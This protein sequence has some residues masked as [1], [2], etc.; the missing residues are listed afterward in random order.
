[1]FLICI[2][3]HHCM[4][5]TFLLSIIIVGNITFVHL[6]LLIIF[7]VCSK[8]LFTFFYAYIYIECVIYHH[9]VTIKLIYNFVCVILHVISYDI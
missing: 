3:N 1:M 7:N 5:D 4:F 6:L 2:K 9:D 8:T